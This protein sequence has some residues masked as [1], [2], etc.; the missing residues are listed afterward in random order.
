MT[1]III[2]EDKNTQLIEHVV[3][4][5]HISN[6]FEYYTDADYGHYTTLHNV[7]GVVYQD[8]KDYEEA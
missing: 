6:K 1:L 5:Q 3:T 8:Y 7:I 4:F 2:F